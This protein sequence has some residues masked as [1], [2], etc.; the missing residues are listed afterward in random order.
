[1]EIPV[2]PSQI[3][4]AKLSKFA[5]ATFEKHA[6]EADP[7]SQSRGRRMVIPLETEGKRSN[8]IMHL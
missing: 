8:V 1:M 5:V 6:G 2:N 3:R 4:L 7:S